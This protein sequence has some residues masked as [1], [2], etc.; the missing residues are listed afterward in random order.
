MTDAVS[1]FGKVAVL[2]GGRSGER[3]VS[4]KSGSAV[5]AALLRQGVDAH[6]FDP[7]ERALSELQQFDRAVIALHGRF[8]EDGTIQGALELMGIP[9]TGSGVMASA[10]GMDKWRTKLLWTA[11][12]I[13]TPSYVLMDDTSSTDDVVGRLGLPLFVKPAN[14]GSSI[15]VTKVKTRDQLA[16]AYVLAKQSDPLVI[17]EQFV[18]GGEYTV[19]ILGDLA[20][21]VIRIVPKNEYYDYEA[22]YLRDD[23]EYRC[24]SGLPAAVEQR[25]QAEALQA[26]KVLGC[27]GWGRVDFLMDE[28]GKH[29]FLEVNTSPGMTDHSLVP[30]A[31]RAIGMDFDKLVLTLLQQTLPQAV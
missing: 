13:V 25:I 1:T 14:E 22:K 12:G 4:L 24:P 7:A 20:L 18:G 11:A 28:A 15:G 27:R 6:A 16:A 10:V 3:E 26:F 8:G 19:G 17:A 2:F 9:Y 21:P 5:L 31:A 30:M 23:T 29:Y